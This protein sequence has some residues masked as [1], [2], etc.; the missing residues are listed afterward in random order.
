[1]TRN[2]RLIRC[3]FI[4]VNMGFDITVLWKA[5]EVNPINRKARSIPVLN[6]FNLYGRVFFF[7]WM[8]FMLA[9]WAW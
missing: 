1:L 4:T 9:F 6:P 3:P 2:T 8:G 7:S 5:P